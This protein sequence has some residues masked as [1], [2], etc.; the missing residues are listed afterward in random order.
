MAKVVKVSKQQRDA[1]LVAALRR[2]GVK[3]ILGP[4]QRLVA[5]QS[6]R[7]TAHT[8]PHG[9]RGTDFDVAGVTGR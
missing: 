7:A 8:D 1:A 9:A 5:E 6:R 3:A 2:T 4:S